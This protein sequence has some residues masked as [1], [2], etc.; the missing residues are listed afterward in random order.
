[1][2]VF[3]DSANLDEIT[4]AH[5]LGVLDGVTTN[6]SLIAKTGRAFAEVAQA[7]TA[8]VNGPVSLEVTATAW[9]SMVAQAH[10]LRKHGQNVVV[11]IPMTADGLKAVKVLAGEKI[12]TNVTLVFQPMQA[13]LAAK[14][15]ATYVSPFVGRHDDIAQDGMCLVRDIITMFRNYQIKT[16]VI[17]ASI[18][19]PIHVIESARMGADIVTLPLKVIHQLIKHPLTDSGLVSFLKDWEKVSNK[20]LV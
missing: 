18:R 15:G 17:V 14:A 11:K 4:E 6:P 2:K 20:S 5:S 12:P 3:I 1:M 8:L 19:H 10:Q 16:E 9:E 13:L 7:I